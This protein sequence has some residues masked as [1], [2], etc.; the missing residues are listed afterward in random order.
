VRHPFYSLG[1]PTFPDALSPEVHSAFRS[2]VGAFGE[3]ESKDSPHPFGTRPIVTFW[4]RHLDLAAR[5]ALAQ[6]WDAAYTNR[7]LDKSKALFENIQEALFARAEDR[8]TKI[9]NGE[10]ISL[11]PP[12]PLDEFVHDSTT[13]EDELSGALAA[14]LDTPEIES[15]NLEWLFLRAFLDHRVRGTLHAHFAGLG[16]TGRISFIL[17]GE[18]PQRA[19]ILKFIGNATQFAF[20][21][22][23]LLGAVRDLLLGH[24]NTVDILFDVGLLALWAVWVRFLWRRARLTQR[25]LDIYEGLMVLDLSTGARIWSPTEALAYLR[26]INTRF[27]LMSPQITVLLE[28]AAQRDPHAFLRDR[29]NYRSQDSWSEQ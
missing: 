5:Q 2:S 24:P 8:K 28:K 4:W 7:Y 19:A 12:T 3:V 23:L 27:D 21:G 6:N 22:F 9:K 11:S 18:R 1:L 13:D 15:E 26:S 16:G 20:M 10:F 14:Y 25:L 29:W 17:A